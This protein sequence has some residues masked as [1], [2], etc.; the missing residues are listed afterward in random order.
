MLA[1][2]GPA[3]AIVG[4][5]VAA[6][7]AWP[8][9]VAL[10][11]PDP[12]IPSI[13]LAHFCGG[14]L[15]NENWVLTAGHCTID[16]SVAPPRLKDAA[17]IDVIA[18]E[19]DLANLSAT[20]RRVAVRSIERAPGFVPGQFAND[21]A[22]LQLDTSI[23]AQST[24]PIGFMNL[25]SVFDQS[26]W[27]P[28][29]DARIVGWGVTNPDRSLPPVSS[30]QL[31]EATVRFIFDG[32]CTA[33]WPVA[34]TALTQICA[35][36]PAVGNDAC[37]ADSGGP[38][39]IVISPG[40]RRVVGVISFGDLK[41]C[42]DAPTVFSRVG[43]GPLRTFIQTQLSLTPPSAPRN[44]IATA[45]VQ[46][47]R[48]S[49]TAPSVPGSRPIQGY[50]VEVNRGA[51]T[52][53]T[54]IIE[55]PAATT[56]T[57]TDLNIF[58]NGRGVA[59]TYAV[60]AISDAGQSAAA[61]ATTAA[62]PR[63]PVWLVAPRVSGLPRVRRELTL[64]PGEWVYPDGN[65][66]PGPTQTNTWQMCAPDG[67]ACATIP[68]SVG[69]TTQTI[70]V[71]AVG[72]R[73]RVAVLVG[74]PGTVDLESQTPLSAVVP[75]TL[76]ATRSGRPRTVGGSVVIR[77]SFATQKGVTIRAQLLGRRGKPVR[78]NGG[79]SRLNGRPA[80][81][82]G[83]TTLQTVTRRSAGAFEIAVPAVTARS[84][85]QGRIVLLATINGSVVT[86]VTLPLTFPAN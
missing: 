81:Q 72:R 29:D 54:R 44:L 28:G 17:E 45:A 12:M 38:I 37:T 36:D 51:E 23:A 25:A 11:N 86:R 71:A 61:E 41:I 68:R 46:Q 84:L 74:P 35:D 34:F 69:G 47:V 76:V 24:P 13:P 55:D 14:T 70:P 30:P 5:S 78:L 53:E 65:P 60:R 67:T 56:T 40:I 15:L 6:P 19:P 2:A 8:S 16:D 79:R 18:G 1:G 64:N 27:D 63:R 59:Q 66:T 22:L 3:Q 73:L 43:S 57:F 39:A 26:R 58:I 52:I 9:T 50:S 48:L 21:I 82:R 75:P 33:A 31:K 7:G 10:I 32:A 80:M 42:G 20:P 83:G 49:W 4:G 85:R 62:L 77:G